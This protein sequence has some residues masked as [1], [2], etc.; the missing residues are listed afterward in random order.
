VA[1]LTIVPLDVL[2]EL[3]LNVPADPSSLERK[4]SET[5]PS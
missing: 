5:V 2:R 3:V 4:R 1:V